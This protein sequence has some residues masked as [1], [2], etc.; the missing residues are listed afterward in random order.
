MVQNTKPTKGLYVDDRNTWEQF[1]QNF[2]F[3][4]KSLDASVRRYFKDGKHVQA[5]A[6]LAYIAEG[7]KYRLGIL[8][9]KLQQ[10]VARQRKANRKLQWRI[11]ELEQRIRKMQET[12]ESV[13]RVNEQE[14]DELRRKLA[15][16]RARIRR[17]T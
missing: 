11:K 13:S 7:E 3:M 14:I 10:R 17:N 8:V 15:K 4:K 5:Y 1:E 6:Y 12:S 16:E 9:N 2:E